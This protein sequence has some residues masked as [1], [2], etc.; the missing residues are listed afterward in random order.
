MH[1]DDLV[2]RREQFKN[3][4][5]IAGH[6]STRY[7]PNAVREMVARALPDMLGGRLQ[8]WL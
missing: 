8:L 5:I 3:Q 6:L 7:H 2:D 1:L 4:L